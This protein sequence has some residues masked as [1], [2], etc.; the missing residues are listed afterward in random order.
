[1]SGLTPT[2]NAFTDGYENGFENGYSAGYKDGHRDR[3]SKDRSAKAASAARQRS[4]TWLLTQQL[5]ALCDYPDPEGMEPVVRTAL[6]AKG[7]TLVRYSET[8]SDFPMN[9][10]EEPSVSND[11]EDED[12]EDEDEG[13]V[14]TAVIEALNGLAIKFGTEYLYDQLTRYMD[15]AF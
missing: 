7:L 2:E 8:T 14:D 1:M 5:C 13:C 6:Q 9:A 4:L 15:N 3:K 10:P 11:A 12:A